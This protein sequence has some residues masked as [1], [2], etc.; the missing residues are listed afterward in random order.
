MFF[1]KNGQRFDEFRL[2]YRP[3][4]FE[5]QQF[6]WSNVADCLVILGVEHCLNADTRQV[7]LIYSMRNFHWYCQQTLVFANEQKQIRKLINQNQLT[8]EFRPLSLL[9]LFDDGTISEYVY[10]NQIDASADGD[11]AVIDGRKLLITPFHYSVV[12]PPMYAYALKFDAEINEICFSQPTAKYLLVKLSNSTL[13]LIERSNRVELSNSIELEFQSISFKQPNLPPIYS[14]SLSCFR[15]EHENL[16]KNC[17]HQFSLTDRRIAYALLSGTKNE[18]ISIDFDNKSTSLL[19]T[20]HRHIERITLNQTDQECNQL[21]VL[22]DQNG[23]VWKCELSSTSNIEPFNVADQKKQPTQVKLRTPVE[24]I[25][26]LTVLDDRCL[27]TLSSNYFLSINH[28]P[29]QGSDCNSFLVHNSNLLIYTTN[30]H[31]LR[32]IWLDDIHYAL[33]TFDLPDYENVNEFRFVREELKAADGEDNPNITKASKELKTFTALSRQSTANNLKPI[34]RSVERG[35]RLVASCSTDCKLIIQMPRGNLE[36]IT[37]RLLVLDRIKFLLNTVQYHLAFQLMKKHRINLNLIVDHDLDCFLMNV[38]NFVQQISH[39]DTSDLCLFISELSMNNVLETMYSAYNQ[40]LRQLGELNLKNKCLFDWKFPELKNANCAANLGDQDC[41][42]GKLI[43]LNSVLNGDSATK[44]A[45]NSVASNLR[46]AMTKLDENKYFIPILLTYLKQPVPS[47]GTALIKIYEQSDKEMRLNALNYLKYIIDMHHLVKE[48]LGTYDLN[49]SKMVYAVSNLDP[50]EYLPLLAKLESYTLTEYR[51]YQIDLH[52]KHYDRALDNLTNCEPFTE[53]ANEAIEL[54]EQKHL[55]QTAIQLFASK[56]SCTQ[57]LNQIYSLYGDYLLVKKYFNEALIVFKKGE[58]YQNA[59]KAAQ[60]TNNWNQII[61]CASLAD[62]QL[63]KL[64][65]PID[66]D[67][68]QNEHANLIRI[69]QSTAEQLDNPNDAKDSSFI[70]GFHLNDWYQAVHVLIKNH[71]WADAYRLLNDSALNEITNSKLSEAQL[72]E[73]TG[74]ADQTLK[75]HHEEIVD[76]LKESLNELRTHTERL[77]TV[78]ENKLNL[79][80]TMNL[81]DNL[82]DLEDEF[83][84]D[85]STVNSIQSGKR[86]VLRRSAYS[87]QSQTNSL[88]T[89]KAVRRKK[90]DESNKY[91]LRVGSRDEDMALIYHINLR[92]KKIEK[93]KPTIKQLIL[94]L[95]DRG[96]NQLASSLQ[97]MFTKLLDVVSFV[98]SVVW[99]DDLL[100]EHQ[101]QNVNELSTTSSNQNEQVNLIHGK[102]ASNLLLPIRY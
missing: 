13:H 48:A 11:C 4:E 35:S 31:S 18:L 34:D 3:D 5:L 19:N 27:I 50:K 92:I 87:N 63:S 75:K 62:R 69:Y 37:P 73:L 100:L 42:D 95:T 66:G 65:E 80:E 41:V 99:Q 21:L 83:L 74:L 79:V 68:K 16:F 67:R 36:I 10:L 25:V 102:R 38:Q 98:V 7:I 24:L 17:F 28:L 54:I 59:I 12:P 55:Y 51:N 56:A 61:E 44:I 32:S 30:D 2:P 58:N 23:L 89:N 26:K 39:R 82:N 49:V 64:N 86:R 101:L 70:Y 72:T 47:I 45:K 40:T 52:L 22:V 53:Y 57:Y 71:Y 78:R 1:E 96:F 15:P 6:V 93:L 91:K 20:E 84:N 94:A 76:L 46:D 77:Q 14:R 90:K 9:M 97:L 29:L 33:E 60:L 8:N 81:A 43:H 85:Q 88:A